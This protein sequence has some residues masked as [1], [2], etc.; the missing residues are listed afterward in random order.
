M[1]TMIVNIENN[2]D[3]QAIFDVVS[4]LKGVTEV[5]I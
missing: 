5:R 3:I 2:I 1:Q 4:K